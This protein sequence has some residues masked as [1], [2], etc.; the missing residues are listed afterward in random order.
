[1][2]TCDNCDF[3]SFCSRFQCTG[4]YAPC[5]DGKTT[6][7]IAGI[8]FIIITFCIIVGCIIFTIYELVNW[9]W[10]L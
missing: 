8:G 2:N 5:E 10:L 4:N 9:R 3:K 6:N 1:M 7:N